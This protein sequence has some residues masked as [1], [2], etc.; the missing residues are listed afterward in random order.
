MRKTFVSNQAPHYRN[1]VLKTAVKLG[2]AHLFT[3]AHASWNNG[4]VEREQRG[5]DN[6]SSR[7]E[8]TTSPG[9]RVA[10]GGDGGAMGS[11]HGVPRKTTDD[12]IP[13]DNRACAADMFIGPIR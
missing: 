9:A 4:T 11:Q 12:T 7:T 6:I 1:K 10:A 3:V 5:G 2:V 13:T 8:Q